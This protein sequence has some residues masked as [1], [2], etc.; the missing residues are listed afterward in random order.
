MTRFIKFFRES[1]ELGLSKKIVLIS[2]SLYLASVFF[3][4]IGISLI[5]PIISLFISGEAV[6]SLVGNQT[7]VSSIIDFIESLGISPNKY[8]FII[9][10]I[11]VIIC[12]QC[13]IFFRASWN[14]SMIAKLVYDLRKKAFGRFLMTKEDFF[15]KESSGNTL[16]DM[17]VEVNQAAV[18]M[19]K[20]VEIIGIITMF[21]VYIGIMLYLSIN[22]TLLTIFSFFIVAYLL[23]GLWSKSSTVGS[24]ITLNNRV[25]MSHVTR[26]FSNLRLLK[27]TGDISFEKK[28]IENITIEQRKKQ[29]K[30]GY[31]IALTNACI[32]PLIF[33]LAAII[34]YGAIEVFGQSLIDIGLFSLILI[35]GVPLARTGFASWQ[36]IEG[37]WASIKAISKTMKDLDNNKENF[38]GTNSLNAS[39]PEIIFDK[40]SYSYDTRNKNTIDSITL[41]IE[42]GEI[43]ALV[44]P[45]GSGK[46]TL[47]DFIPRLKIPDSG[48]ILINKENIN[49]INLADLRSNIGFLPQTPQILDGT[50][51]DHVKFGNYKLSDAEILV[52]LKKAGLES[53]INKLEY[54]ID[55]NIGDNGVL[56]SGGEKQ[57][58]DLARVLARKASILILDEPASNLDLVTEDLII[59]AILEEQ[60]THNKTIILIG[61]RLKAFKIFDKIIVLNHGIIEAFGSH[62]MVLRNSAWYKKA[63]LMGEQEN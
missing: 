7:V 49:D 58:V 33:I 24:Q 15:K 42:P 38:S 62:D 43:I 44:G 59:K 61:H 2:M 51:K 40:V 52:S 1:Y 18:I 4:A 56:L 57:R 39:P 63:W 23:K 28:L 13:V 29:F 32:E 41:K 22:L 16:N 3:E 14:A 53:M 60:K 37:K 17:S 55:T 31:L 25:F 45:S 5:L 12:R 50:I 34:L 21:I 27:L 35:R 47:I 36:G 6:E 19:I 26:R 8:N 10:F 9:I 20:G 54:G 46:S 48:N 11:I 30:A